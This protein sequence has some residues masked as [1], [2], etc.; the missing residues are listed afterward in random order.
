[1]ST[2]ELRARKIYD[3]CHIGSLEKD[4]QRQLIILMLN[5]GF[6]NETKPL[7]HESKNYP[8]PYTVEELRSRIAEAEADIFAG[9]TLDPEDVEAELEKKY[10]WLCE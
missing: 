1:M 7:E 8:E 9:R 2:V 10:P 6:N 3:E 5:N 4:V